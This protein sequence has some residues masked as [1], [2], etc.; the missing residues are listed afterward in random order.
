M[1]ILVWYNT[2]CFGKI[3]LPPWAPPPLFAP[4][5]LAE[6]RKT[7]TSQPTILQPNNE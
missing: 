4:A 5:P 6:N 3:I 7:P 2:Y 1:R